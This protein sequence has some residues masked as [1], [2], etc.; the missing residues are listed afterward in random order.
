MAIRE[1]ATLMGAEEDWL[2]EKVEGRPR[3]QSLRAIEIRARR[4]GVVQSIEVTDGALVGTGDL[5]LR[6]IEPKE[7]RFRGFALQADLGTITDGSPVHIVPPHGGI[8]SYSESLEAVALLG[9]EA[10]PDERTID[11]IATP[12]GSELP[13]WAR[14]GVAAFVEIVVSGSAERELAIPISAVAN[15]GADRIFFLRDRN[16][17]DRVRRVV[18][19]LGGD[20]GRWIIVNSGVRRGD[21]VVLEGAYELKLTGSGTEQQGGHFHG[22]GTFHVGED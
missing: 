18:A 19:D 2:I 3:W 16:D 10:D 11:V 14:P 1:A 12:V 4:S 5:I 20:D 13:V 22:D 6:T 9:T 17:P 7:I 21:E 8:S 15:D